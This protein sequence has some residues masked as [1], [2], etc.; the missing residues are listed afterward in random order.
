MSVFKSLRFRIFFA[1]IFVLALT[2]IGLAILTVIQ[3]REEAKD[4]HRKPLKIRRLILRNRTSN[5]I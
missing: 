2:F 1:M 4:Y 3:Y 5:K